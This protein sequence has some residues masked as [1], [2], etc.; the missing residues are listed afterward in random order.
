[1]SPQGSAIRQR[2]VWGRS[3]SVKLYA[4]ARRL[5]GRM[6]V[7]IVLKTFY[8]PIPDLA[9]LPA[10]IWDEV[11][12]MRGI[13]WDL[14]EQAERLLTLAA[15]IAEFTP[16]GVAEH[17]YEP[18][19][20]SY[21]LADARLLYAIVR[22]L[23]PARIVELGSGQTSRVISQACVANAA[24][25]ATMTH[26]RAF[27]PFPSPATET[28]P[29]LTSLER[30]PAQEVPDEVVRELSAGDILFVDTTHTVKMGS[31]V[32]HII[33]RV[34]PLLAE[35]VVVHFHD[36]CFPYQYPRYLVEDY[37]LYWAEQYLLQAF[38]A[39]NPYFEVLYATAALARDRRGAVE[40]AG[41][42]E[43]SDSGSSFWIRRRQ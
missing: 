32:N 24:D 6:G 16:T 39:M 27:D 21:P 31:D 40:R 38:L 3:G 30:L 25:G 26:Y 5:A 41:L 17:D 19:N 36:I 1:M 35:G 7:Q 18:S 43:G 28:L 9:T 20:P 33:L 2:R 10:G 23:R 11:D 42:A 15:P 29:G 13:E 37:G 14:D 8:S 12:P 4:L 34:L 22:D